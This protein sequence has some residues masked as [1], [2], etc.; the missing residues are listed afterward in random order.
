MGNERV[1]RGKRPDMSFEHS[2]GL[3]LGGL[4]IFQQVYFTIIV[5]KLVNKLMSRNYYEY[6]QAETQFDRKP[7]LNVKIAEEEDP[8]DD[9][10]I[11]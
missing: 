4:L 3:G 2:L 8:V 1:S 6:A 10:S 5:N 7:D 11:I 9:M